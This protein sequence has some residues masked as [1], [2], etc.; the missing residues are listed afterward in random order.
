MLHKFG[1]GHN[2]DK[3]TKN[4]CSAKGEGAV[5]HSKINRWSKKF[6]SGCKTSD[7]QTKSGR[8]KTLDSE[9]VL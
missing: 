8:P 2:A 7:D 5:Y 3:A 4:V 6:C 9:V 1:L